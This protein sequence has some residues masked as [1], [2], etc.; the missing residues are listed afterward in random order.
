MTRRSCPTPTQ[1]STLGQ[2]APQ[3]A[4]RSP[5]GF[6]WPLGS[7]RRGRTFLKDQAPAPPAGSVETI[8]SALLVTAAQA[9]TAGQEAAL[10]GR[11]LPAVTAFQAP[12]PPV[13][14]VEDSIWPELPVTQ[15]EVEGQ[16]TPFSARCPAGCLAT[17]QVP[18]PP[19]G[20]VEV[21]MLPSS[22]TATQSEGEGQATP[23]RSTGSLSL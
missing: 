13:G 5:F 19:V 7:S 10:T 1:R 2:E 15:S 23:R 6:S 18:V 12:A 8:T 22:P 4:L 9:P 11:P 14:E 17:C 3:I 20:S 16:E 21:R